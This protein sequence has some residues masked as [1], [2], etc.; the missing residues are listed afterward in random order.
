MPEVNFRE[1]RLDKVRRIH[2]LRGGVNK[3]VHTFGHPFVTASSDRIT[4]LRDVLGT[5]GC[6]LARA[7]E[8]KDKIVGTIAE[9]RKGTL[10][11]PILR[12]F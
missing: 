6:Y 3:P 10:W 11:L 8:R 5:Y 1:F 2:L 7:R 12:T 4:L 9:P